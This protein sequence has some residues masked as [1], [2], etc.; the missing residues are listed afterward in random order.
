MPKHA[1]HFVILAA[2]ALLPVLINAQP[3]TRN[4]TAYR[5]ALAEAERLR[6]EYQALEAEAER[7]GEADTVSGAI[8]NLK[9]RQASLRTDIINLENYLAEHGSTPAEL[10]AL[11]KEIED[12][13]DDE[14]RKNQQKIA[15]KI[16]KPIVQRLPPALRAVVWVV[17]RVPDGVAYIAKELDIDDI[18]EQIKHEHA[19][20]GDLY[21]INKARYI[22]LYEVQEKERRVVAL[23]TRID[24]LIEKTAHAQKRA[25]LLK[26]PAADGAAQD[27]DLGDIPLMRIMGV[28]QFRITNPDGST[29]DG[30]F[31][32]QPGTP[33]QGVFAGGASNY[34][35]DMKL[36]G[37]RFTARPTNQKMD[38]I[39]MPDGSE[40]RGTWVDGYST[41]SGPLPAVMKHVKS[42]AQV[43]PNIMRL[44]AQAV[45]VDVE[46]RFLP[47]DKRIQGRGVVFAEAP[48]KVIRWYPLPNS[49]FMRVEISH[50]PGQRSGRAFLNV[51]GARVGFDFVANSGR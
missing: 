43:R 1:Q 5:E 14:K 31:V 48:Y 34:I 18:D 12:A 33:Y 41:F 32:V 16:V 11:R 50:E 22:E 26:V 40:M 19:R 8:D 9:N 2:V 42:Y 49:E 20:I 27:R 23:K 13:W 37:N 3:P 28:W 21:L 36:E 17:K 7:I 25:D 38:M 30:F 46:G 44:S 6:R 29:V 15:D 45:A 47:T 35:E 39:L 10:E 24:D 51:N 4:N